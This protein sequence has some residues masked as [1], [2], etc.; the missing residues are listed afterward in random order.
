MADVITERQQTMLQSADWLAR[1][2]GHPEKVLSEY[3]L[4]GVFQTT[5]QKRLFYPDT[6]WEYL[7][8]TL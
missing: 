4:D 6:L 1:N 5:V 7:A 2:C 3:I 8:V